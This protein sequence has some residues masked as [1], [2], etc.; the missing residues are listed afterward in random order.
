[1]HLTI[2]LRLLG[3][4][5]SAV[6]F[7]LAL[8][9]TGYW[10]ITSLERSTSEVAGMGSAIRSHVEAGIF[11]DLTRK[12]VTTVFT[13]KGEDQQ[14]A[15]R[16]TRQ[17]FEWLQARITA[18]RDFASD[19]ASREM[20][21]QEKELGERYVQ[22]G[23]ALLNA[24]LEKPAEAPG[25]LGPY[26][27]LYKEL[28]AK[29][30]QT[31]DQLTASAKQAEAAA[32]TTAARA[33]RAM[34]TI[35]VISLIIM[36]VGSLILVRLISSSLSR[37]VQMM[38]NIA[39]GEGDLTKRIETASKF[40]SD[41][42]GEVSRL[43]NLFMDKLQT[44]LRGVVGHT[45]KLAAATHLLVDASEQITAHSG[46]TAS[47]SNS[48]S[49]ATE[50]V[51]HNLNSLSE[52]VGQMTSTIQ[53]IA[54][55]AQEAAK[56]ASSAMDMAQSANAT[57]AKLGRSSAEIGEVIKVITSIAQQTNLLA[58]N[59]TIEAARAGEAGKGFA[60]VANEVKELAKQTAKATE[61]IGLRIA[62]IQAD[63]KGAVSAIATV[64]GVVTQ[65]NEISATI[66]SAVDQQ[67]ATTSEM[68]RNAGEAASGA[69]QI[70]TNIREV[71][72][73]ADDTAS[74]ARESQK[75]TTEL[76]SIT[77][78][79]RTLM[80][81]FKIERS[82]PRLDMTVPV[83]LRATDI[84]G[85]EFEQ[86]VTTV[87]IARHGAHLANVK[88]RLQVE[89]WATLSR[90]GKS[91]RFQIAWIGEANTPRAGHIGLSAPEM[92]PSFWEDVLEQRQE[93][94]RELASV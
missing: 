40:G 82:E 34:F 50:L 84:D 3:M 25:L 60:V 13:A 55:N 68:T 21:E 89:E 5:M 42:I 54:T 14:T 86:H 18:A 73:A 47:Q 30:E 15:A 83:T 81:Q 53:S 64:S 44:I 39:Q 8:S 75:A 22:A 37:L 71:S 85:R 33:T 77:S 62:A 58:L 1:M 2:K 63:T 69:G 43:F 80:R 11:N 46:N 88:G 12:D 7:V 66:A 45:H 32:K 10:G 91:Q 59:A 20:L 78:E 67:A 9:A 70:S 31:S 49:Q 38:Q 19:P 4:A 79:L 48:V 28:Q 90:Q 76:S 24:M 57:V 61:D 56:V 23:N 35:F 87:D 93:A 29:M 26:L 92:D 74:R 17:H 6:G 16:E 65:I 27:E 36:S 51:S 72:H 94:E 52:G 41:E